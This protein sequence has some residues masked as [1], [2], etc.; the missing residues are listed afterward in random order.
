MI[1]VLAVLGIGTSAAEFA[2][3]KSDNTTIRA[4]RDVSEERIHNANRK[5]ESD[6]R[7]IENKYAEQLS[8]KY[9]KDIESSDPYV[10]YDASLRATREAFNLMDKE[11]IET[12]ISVV[13]RA[14]YLPEDYSYDKD[15]DIN[16]VD[17]YSR[18]L[19]AMCKT[20]NDGNFKMTTDE[21][22]WFLSIISSEFEA[23]KRESGLYFDISDQNLKEM[24]ETLAG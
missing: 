5:L 23:S 9:E 14:G 19:S 10:V 17:S 20:L 11:V 8:Y 15:Y 18:F 2:L 16:D 21:E 3:N 24:E 13:K 12:V 4:N 1:S 7:K 6:R 22:D